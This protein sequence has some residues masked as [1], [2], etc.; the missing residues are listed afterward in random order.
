MTSYYP[1]TLLESIKHLNFKLYYSKPFGN[2]FFNSIAKYFR[3]K[4]KSNI[5]GITI[6]KEIVKYILNNNNIFNYIISILGIKKKELNMQ[7]N[8][9][10]KNGVYEL[11]VFDIIPLIIATK[12]N[13]K[14][15]IYTFMDTNDTI[16]TKKDC[17]TYYPIDNRNEYLD[18]ISLLYANVEHYD[19]LYYNK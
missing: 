5:T 6:R 14:I 9:L 7:L 10:R 18:E 4:N 12:Y 15:S 3:L 11:D 17:E 8:E 13:V 16:I 19:L 2:C 1:E